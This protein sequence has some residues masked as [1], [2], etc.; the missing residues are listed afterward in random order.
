MS[1]LLRA[2][3]RRHLHSM[4]FWICLLVSLGLGVLNGFRFQEYGSLD[5]ERV[6]AGFLIFTVLISISIGKEFHEGGIR[7]KVIV[8]YS[9]AKVFFSEWLLATLSTF[10]CFVLIT[11]PVV[12]MNLKHIECFT[13][14]NATKIIV[15]MLL[16]NVSV[17]VISCTICMI[18]SHRVV[19]PIICILLILCT[20]VL[21]NSISGRLEAPKHE[22]YYEYNQETGEMDEFISKDIN[23]RY[24]DE[25]LRTAL[26]IFTNAVPEGQIKEY[27]DI[28]YEAN[29][30]SEYDY[31]NERWIP[32]NLT[33]EQIGVLNAHPYYS[34][35]TIFIFSFVGLFVFK[36]KNLN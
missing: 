29:G 3:I 12:L 27:M 32:Y 31:D 8:G 24:I 10:L 15:G 5:E 35:G 26:D 6:I 13:A 4:V 19:A 33:D 30:Y 1:K 7:N 22:F 2:G 25:P 18:F 34:L 17:S 11:I 23:P 20:F 14:T 21:S 9:R 36:K 28:L 16:V